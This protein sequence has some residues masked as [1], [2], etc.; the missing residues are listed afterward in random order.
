[1]INGK[2]QDATSGKTF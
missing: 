1:L 2:W